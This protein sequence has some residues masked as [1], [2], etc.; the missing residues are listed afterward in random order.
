M[1]TWLDLIPPPGPGE[2]DTAWSGYLIPRSLRDPLAE[3]YE[4]L[5]TR[6]G[7]GVPAHLL[8]AYDAAGLAARRRVGGR[9]TDPGMIAV[10]EF[11]STL[12]KP[13]PTK[14]WLRQGVPARRRPAHHRHDDP[15]P[16]APPSHETRRSRWPSRC[17]A[18]RR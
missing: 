12:A 10:P 11:A 16:T 7:A 2:V 17:C 14:A 13:V 6:V 8:P 3:R 5:L 18:T 4:R 15:E 1:F 9:L